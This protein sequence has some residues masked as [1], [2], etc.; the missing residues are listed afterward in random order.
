MDTQ[1]G[2]RQKQ[3]IEFLRSLGTIV[4]PIAYPADAAMHR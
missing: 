4:N 1:A 3:L 2:S